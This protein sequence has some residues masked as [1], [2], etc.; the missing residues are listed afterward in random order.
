MNA[1]EKLI[2]QPAAPSNE[3]VYQAILE[4]VLEA[5]SFS[6]GTIHILNSET[7]LL[8]LV[9]HQG[10]P[11]FLLDK[12]NTIPIGKGIAGVAAERR[13]AV[14]MCNL[15]TDTSGVARPDA[16]KTNVAGNIAVPMLKGDALKGALG[17]GLRESHDFTN[18]EIAQ[19]NQV[20]GWLAQA[21]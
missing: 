14:Q 9:A 1:I 11:E 18:E 8:E 12:V 4:S 19:L 15:Q 13:E 6:T 2:A 3:G 5:F 16:K 10:I 20:A 21:L 17:I 7:Q